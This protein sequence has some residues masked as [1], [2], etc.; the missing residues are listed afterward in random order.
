MDAI[1]GTERRRKP[2]FG[3]AGLHVKLNA[4][5]ALSKSL[6]GPGVQVVEKEEKVMAKKRAK[7][8]QQWTVLQQK[9]K[10]TAGCRAGGC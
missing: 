8:L 7:V 1:P 4:A 3:K 10:K 6:Q 2:R 5:H 9:V